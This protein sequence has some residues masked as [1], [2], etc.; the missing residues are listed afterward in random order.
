MS[1]TIKPGPRPRPG[2]AAVIAIRV[3]SPDQ[4]GM[5]LTLTPEERGKILY[6]YVLQQAQ[7]KEVND[8]HA[9]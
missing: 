3:T 2:K 7:Q 8:A 4:Y 9:G 1:D 6:E 5:I